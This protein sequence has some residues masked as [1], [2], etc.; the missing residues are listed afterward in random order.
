[1]NFWSVPPSSRSAFSDR[2]VTLHQRV[3]EFVDRDRDA[4]L[5]ALREVLALEDPRDRVARRELDHPVGAERHRPLAVVADLGLVA[6]E[7]QRGLVEVGLRVRLDLLARE[8]R[9]RRVAAGRIAD[10]RREIADQ[11]DHRVPEVL[12]LAHLVQHDRVADVDVG[13]GRVEPE[14]DAQRLAGGRAARELLR[15]LFLDQQFVDTALRDGE[16][17]ADFVGDRKTGLELGS[18]LIGARKNVAKTG[19]FP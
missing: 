2:V 16:R 10:Q 1:L 11:E 18:V 5:E 15:E 19:I 12:Q 13:R 14:L 4:A 9:A 17:V 6:V 8:R 3:Q 7:H